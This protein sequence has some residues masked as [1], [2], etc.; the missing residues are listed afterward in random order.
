MVFSVQYSR[1]PSL[2][3][4]DN[5]HAEGTILFKMKSVPKRFE[6][7]VCICIYIYIYIYIYLTSNY[8]GATMNNFDVHGNSTE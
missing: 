2:L 6:E 1:E 4:K 5:F 7:S 8:L 3:Q